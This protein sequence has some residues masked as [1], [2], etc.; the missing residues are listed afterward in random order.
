MALRLAGGENPLIFDNG[1]AR[2]GPLP[3]AMNQGMARQTGWNENHTSGIVSEQVYTQQYV[4]RPNASGWEKHL[5]VGANMFMPKLEDPSV[6]LDDTAPRSVLPLHAVNMML[7]R[8]YRNAMNKWNRGGFVGKAVDPYLQVGVPES[9]WSEF[10]DTTDSDT[11]RDEDFV[12]LHYLTAVGIMDRINYV[13][14]QTTEPV[15]AGEISYSKGE[16]SAVSVYQGPCDMLNIFPNSWNGAECFF[17]LRRIRVKNPETKQHE[18]GPF[19]FVPYALQ[20]GMPCIPKSQLA[21]ESVTKT[22]EEGYVIHAGKMLDI[23]GQVA[24]E[25]RDAFYQAWGTQT[26]HETKSKEEALAQLKNMP[27]CRFLRLSTCG[28]QWIY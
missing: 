13:G 6:V 5:P 26:F 10:Y 12:N 9:A 3:S 24:A 28:Q 20:P 23:Q 27:W 7:A 2:P 22:W 11:R 14:V 16:I 4:P 1:M 25:N 21:Y 17:I 18:W 15:R 19:A 8:F